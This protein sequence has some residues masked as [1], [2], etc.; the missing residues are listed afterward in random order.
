LRGL[1]QLANAA[2]SR[3][4][5]NKAPASF[6]LNEKLAARLFDNNG[7]VE[8]I[9]VSGTMVSTVQL[10]LAGVASLFP[11]GSVARTWKLWAPSVKLL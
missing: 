10:K 2:P 9:V 4:Q 5:W 1:L 3:L 11:A 6:E 8:L 7:G